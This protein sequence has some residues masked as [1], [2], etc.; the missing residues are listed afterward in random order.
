MQTSPLLEAL[1]DAL[2]CLPGV[3]P[4]SAQRMAFQLLQRDRSGGMR[5]AQALTRAMS[6]IGHCRDCRTFTEQEQC[7]I[8]ANPRRQQTGL[9]CV[10]ESPA[11]IH[12]I[13]QTGQF[14]GRYFVLMGHLSPLDGIGPMDIGLDKLEARLAQETITEVILATNPTVEG[15]ATANYIAEMCAQYDVSA[16]RIA[17][18]VPVGG[19]L[20]MVDGTTLSHS[21]AGRQKIRYNSGY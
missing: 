10:V 21:I 2:R 16:S 13:E 11:D 20:E 15:E 3:G 19:E 18:G 1:M 17:H 14:S 9:I 4:K 6:E 5:L 7:T 12:A 8:C